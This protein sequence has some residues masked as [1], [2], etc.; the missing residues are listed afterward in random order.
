MAFNYFDNSSI[1]GGHVR[2]GTSGINS[3][4]SNRI[5]GTFTGGGVLFTT[6]GEH[7]LLL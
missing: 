3:V 4:D 5:H 2:S 6:V 1:L 7:F